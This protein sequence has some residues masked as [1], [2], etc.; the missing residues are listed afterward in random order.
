MTARQDAGN[1]VIEIKDNGL[2]FDPGDAGRLF[3]VFQ[4]L[5]AAHNIDGT[6]IGL[7]LCSSIVAAHGGTIAAHS[8]GPEQGAVFTLTLPAT[9]P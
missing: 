5:H 2:G 7:A 4:R 1:W 6:G 9:R 8:D 3:Q